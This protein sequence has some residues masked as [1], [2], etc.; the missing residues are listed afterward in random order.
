MNLLPHCFR[1]IGQSTSKT[2]SARQG[3]Q[4]AE[5]AYFSVLGLRQARDADGPAY[6]VEACIPG[7][8]SLDLLGLVEQET[9]LWKREKGE[10]EKKDGFRVEDRGGL[11]GRG[12]VAEGD[13]EVGEVKLFE[14]LLVLL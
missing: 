6:G 5:E 13:G 14:L 7:H 3:K 12:G 9:E 10:S 4:R 1:N 11:G 8:L 2:R